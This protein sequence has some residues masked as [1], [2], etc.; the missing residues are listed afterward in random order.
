MHI[1]TYITKNSHKESLEAFTCE[2][3]FV[4]SF[5][6]PPGQLLNWP[7]WIHLT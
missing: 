6:C 7:H 1:N 2:Q 4:A 5:P 3:F